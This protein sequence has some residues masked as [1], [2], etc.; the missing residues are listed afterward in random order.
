MLIALLRLK[1]FQFVDAILPA[2]VREPFCGRQ[3]TQKLVVPRLR[4]LLAKT[5]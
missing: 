4:L 2:V 3:T 1:P 5:G